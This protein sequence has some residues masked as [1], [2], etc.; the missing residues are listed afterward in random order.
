MSDSIKLGGASFGRAP[1]GHQQ[2]NLNDMLI[3]GTDT[4]TNTIEVVNK[5]QPVV[6][7]GGIE[8]ARIKKMFN[9]VESDGHFYKKMFE[10]YKAAAIAFQENMEAERRAKGSAG[11]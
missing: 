1:T 5:K 11:L 3:L 4:G 7:E 2:Q 6:P 8:S 9:D 10:V